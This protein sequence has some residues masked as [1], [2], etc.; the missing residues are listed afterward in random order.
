MTCSIN[1]KAGEKT[2]M[3]KQ[4]ENVWN[5]GGIRW[6]SVPRNMVKSISDSEGGNKF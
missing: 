5:R 6:H 1:L 2:Q 4:P 3:V